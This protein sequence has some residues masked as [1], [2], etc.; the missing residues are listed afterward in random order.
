MPRLNVLH[1]TTA[2]FRYSVPVK[3]Q[4]GEFCGL[5]MYLCATAAYYFQP[6]ASRSRSVDD[7]LARR[8]LLLE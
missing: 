4:R 6:A 8:R 2:P 1:L 3:L 7:A 5:S